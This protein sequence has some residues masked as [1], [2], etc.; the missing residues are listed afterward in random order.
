M[1]HKYV[2]VCSSEG[3][4]YLSNLYTGPVCQEELRSL[5]NCILGDSDT[6]INPVIVT[7]STSNVEAAQQLLSIVD[8]G[9]KSDLISSDCAAE[10]KPF[11]CLYFFDIYVATEGVSYQPSAAHC[12][13]L[14]DDICEI[15]WVTVSKILPNTLPNCDVEF[16]DETVLCTSDDGYEGI[17]S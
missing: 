14:R 7:D 3:S 5:E 10:V 12:R 17:N 16:A 8:G 9:I 2:G 1:A 6:S 13:N 4:G 11:I 15:E